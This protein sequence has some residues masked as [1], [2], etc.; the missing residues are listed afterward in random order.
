MISGI[1][2]DLI[3]KEKLPDN[4]FIFKTIPQFR[5]L[6]KTSVFITHGGFNSVKE[7]IHAQVPMLVYPVDPRMD[8]NGNAARIVYHQLGLRGDLSKDSEKDIAQKINKLMTDVMYKKN[9]KEMLKKD[10]SYSDENFIA[11]M[12]KIKPL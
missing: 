10:Q 9:L 8:Q 2:F 12:K 6:S 11:L 5:I 7:S 1:A 3:E 4:V